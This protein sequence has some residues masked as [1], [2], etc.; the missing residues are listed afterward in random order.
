M[1]ERAIWIT[2]CGKSYPLCLTLRATKEIAKRF[3][4]LENLADALSGAE[5]PDQLDTMTWLL[6]LL[7]TEGSSMLRVMGEEAPP[8]LTAEMLEIVLT[9]GDLIEM[10]GNLLRT[11]RVGVGREVEGKNAEAGP[12]SAGSLP[13]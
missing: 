4:G 5:L 7:M 10:Q 13:G 12:T 9:P 6:S 3:G 1:T 2:I 8:P 11:V